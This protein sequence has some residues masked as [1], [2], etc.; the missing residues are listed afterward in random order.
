MTGM[1]IV[2]IDTPQFKAK[3][4]H[5][6]E[7]PATRILMMMNEREPARQLDLL[8]QTIK[9]ALIDQDNVQALESLSFDQILQVA[10]QYVDLKP[11]LTD[12]AE[13]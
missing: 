9:S 6:G 1:N 11:T 7:L 5:I 8:L 4:L 13:F 2:T 3:A 12:L 10:K